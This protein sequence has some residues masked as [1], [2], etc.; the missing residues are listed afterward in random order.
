VTGHGDHSEL[1][2]YIGGLREDLGRAEERIHALEERVRD[3]EGQT[4]QAQQAQYEA[5]IAA[6]DLAESGYDRDPPIGAD[7][8]GADCKCPYC[9]DEDDLEV[10][11]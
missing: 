2:D 11:R 4:P 9:Y 10:A 6:A 8:H 1:W 3:L 5:D 7:R